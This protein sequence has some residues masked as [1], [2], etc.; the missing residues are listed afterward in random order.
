M[1]AGITDLKTHRVRKAAQPFS[2]QVGAIFKSEADFCYSGK[3]FAF[4]HGYLD[5]GFDRERRPT[6]HVTVQCRDYFVN[7]QAKNLLK[8]LVTEGFKIEKL[9]VSKEFLRKIKSGEAKPD[10]AN[11]FGPTATLEVEFD[12]ALRFLANREDGSMGSYQSSRYGFGTDPHLVY[13]AAGVGFN[14]VCCGYDSRRGR[15]QEHVVDDHCDIEELCA[16]MSQIRAGQVDDDDVVF[17]VR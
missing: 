14:V 17:F 4:A 11:A 7:E 12:E 16:M 15:Y 1:T 2:D 3:F 6:F 9:A 13:D 5:S 8:R 10:A